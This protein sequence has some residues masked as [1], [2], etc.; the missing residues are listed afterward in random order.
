MPATIEPASSGRATCR[1]CGEKIAAGTLRLGDQVPN[2]YADDGGLTTQW[3]HLWCGAFRRPE[4]TLEALAGETPDLAAAGVDRDALAREAQLGVAHHRLP[5]VSTVGLAPTGR[6][7]CRACKALIDK[8]TWRIALMY[9]ED[10]RFSPSGYIH[11][12]CA[13]AYLET[14]DILPRVRHFSPGLTDDDVAALK[15][16][17]EVA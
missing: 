8:D 7:T 10:G 3:Y 4:S 17:L 9:F 14:T 15:A 13:R 1:G 12:G 5:R 11:A 6:A 2:T 16:A